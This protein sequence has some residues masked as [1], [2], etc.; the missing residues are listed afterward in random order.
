MPVFVY[1]L[2]QFVSINTQF[3]TEFTMLS[4]ISII[5][6]RS[7]SNLV[8]NLEQL[9][10]KSCMLSGNVHTIIQPKGC[11]VVGEKQERFLDCLAWSLGLNFSLCL[12]P[13]S[14][15]C[16]SLIC[17]QQEAL[18]SYK[19]IEKPGARRRCRRRWLCWSPRRTSRTGWGKVDI[20]ASK[21]AGHGK[22][23]FFVLSFF[24]STDFCVA[25]G[26]VT[27]FCNLTFGCLSLSV[28]SWE[29]QVLNIWKD[30]CWRW[31][32]CPPPPPLW[33][34]SLIDLSRSCKG[35]TNTQWVQFGTNWV[36]VATPST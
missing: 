22:K 28:M 30:K 35:R 9:T 36:A 14:R 4:T 17:E 26:C 8:V 5:W 12:N 10:V 18:Q 34:K 21:W 24:P 1:F 11:A 6:T 7:S 32:P 29:R 20:W 19:R 15:L 13:W 3:V 33:S 27:W 25:L 31:H 16:F 23:T 2:S